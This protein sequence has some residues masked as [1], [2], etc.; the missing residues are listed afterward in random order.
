MLHPPQVSAV[1]WRFAV[2]TGFAHLQP[3]RRWTAA[4]SRAGT[5][6]SSAAKGYLGVSPLDRHNMVISSNL[7]FPRIGAGRELKRALDRYW[8]GESGETELREVGRAI[9]RESWEMQAALGISHIPS[10]DSSLYDHVLDAAVAVGAVPE[11]FRRL[12]GLAGYF[13]MARGTGS[14]SPLRLTKWFDT[15]YHYLVPEFEPEQDFQPESA[16]PVGEFLEAKALGIRTRPVLLGPLSLLLL[17]RMRDASRPPLAL[18]ERIIPAYEELLRRLAAAGAEW[19]QLDEPVLAQELSPDALGALERAYERLARAAPGL[20]RLVATY[21]GGLHANLPLALRLPVEALHLDLV[22][23]PEQIVPAVECAPVT[24]SLSLGVVDGRNVWR[25]DLERALALLERARDGLGPDRVLVAPSCSLAHCPLDLDAETS[26]DSEVRSWLAFARQKLAE[27][28]ILSTALGRGREAVHAALA[29][30]RA[31]VDARRRSAHVHDPRVRM[32]TEAVCPPML[33]R[34]SSYPERRDRQREILPLPLMPTTTIGS[35]PQ[36]GAVRAARAA[37]K[38]GRKSLADY[39]DFLRSEIRQAIRFQEEIGL[40][41]LVHGEFERSDMVEYFGEQLNGFAVTG[42][43]WVQSY[44][45]RC[46]KP[47]IIYGDVSRRGPLTVRWS[48][49]AQSLTDKPVK[50]MLTGPVTMLQWCFVRDDQPRWLTCRQISLALR[51]EIGDLQAAGIRVI[52]VDEPAIREGLP[53]HREQWKEYLGWAVEAFR[54]ATSGAL[55]TTQLHTHMCYSDF[56]DII[57]AIVEL[58]ADVLSVEG[59]RSGMRILDALARRRYPNAVGPGVYDIHSP[60]VPSA[61]EIEERLREA[62][63]ALSPEQ[64]WVNPDCGLKTRSW[65]EV[66]AALEAMVS[67]ARR[68]RAAAIPGGPREAPS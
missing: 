34:N 31:V 64:I 30:S 54:L 12:R 4:L 35:L 24:L 8:S 27:I 47:P 39:E 7:G 11:R 5:A 25:T 15:N 32:R 65:P 44:G 51:D 22:R 52:Q 40:D 43:G 2:G 49:F 33:H 53:L 57:N 61:E 50:G 59:A 13:A 67:A 41:V 23:A 55:D 20:R 36:T 10:N 26:L 28:A 37:F 60:R 18:L 42:H 62:Q 16:K 17:G 9:R 46:V 6:G 63:A 48:C 68:L 29:E 38:A 56:D 66:R 19:V 58:D 3:G 14:L 1:F 45:S 21:F